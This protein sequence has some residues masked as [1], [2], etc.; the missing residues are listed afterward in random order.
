MKWYTQEEKLP[1][2][3]DIVVVHHRYGPGWE[4]SQLVGGDL[5]IVRFEHA[6][7]GGNNHVP[8]QWKELGGPMCY[9][10][11]NIDEWAYLEVDDKILHINQYLCEGYHGH[12]YRDGTGVD[13]A[14]DKIRGKTKQE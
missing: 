1:N 12:V 8:Y 10:G 4:Q 3:G 11:Q 13:A 14:F 9:F 5:S 2:Y 7:V 6:N